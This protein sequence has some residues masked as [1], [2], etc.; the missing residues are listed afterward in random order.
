MTTEKTIIEVNGIKLEI[1]LRHAKRIDQFKIG[2]NVKV[3]IKEYS[4]SFTAYPGV[5]VSFDN[6]EKR[7]TIVI[8]YLK[9]GYNNEIKFCYFNSESKD[10][11]ICHMGDHE[12]TLEKGRCVDILEKEIREI[13]FKLDELNRKKN[14]FLENYNRHFS[15]FS[16]N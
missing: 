12:R 11:E 8:C 10:I 14:Y 16:Q 4:D 3:L 9:T 1:D 15:D 7:P 6:F 13:E 5:I 2:D